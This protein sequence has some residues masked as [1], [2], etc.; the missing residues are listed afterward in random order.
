MFCKRNITRHIDMYTFCYNDMHCQRVILLQ[1]INVRQISLKFLHTQNWETIVKIPNY[2]SE[3]CRYM[4]H[5]K[6]YYPTTIQYSTTLYASKHVDWFYPMLFGTVIVFSK[7]FQRQIKCRFWVKH[8]S[9]S[10]YTNKQ[11]IRHLLN[12]ITS[13]TPSVGGPIC[14]AAN[15]KLAIVN[16]GRRVVVIAR[17]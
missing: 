7:Y 4:S 9:V 3:F 15:Y 14:E 5:I 16:T 8:T 1:T 12:E 2:R 10:P 6:R 13:N 17:R 11:I